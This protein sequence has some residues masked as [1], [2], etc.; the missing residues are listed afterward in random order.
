MQEEG[1]G[2][3]KWCNV[4]VV[5][6]F[7]TAQ[8]QDHQRCSILTQ[9]QTGAEATATE[10]C[11]KLIIAKAKQAGQEHLIRVRDAKIQ[12]LETELYTLRPLVADL[13]EGGGE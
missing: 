3:E 1:K 6:I 8:I 10:R 11:Q 7:S 9:R 5:P 13:Q 2:E 12:H 4:V